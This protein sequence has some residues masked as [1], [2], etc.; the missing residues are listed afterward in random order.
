M[1]IEQKTEYKITL[2]DEELADLL[3]MLNPWQF[4]ANVSPNEQVS[5]SQKAI[6]RTLADI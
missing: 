2:N 1:K 5:S 4:A 3:L 6:Y